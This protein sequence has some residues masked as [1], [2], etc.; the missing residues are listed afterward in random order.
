MGS[1]DVFFPDFLENMRTY[2][3][4]EHSKRFFIVTDKQ[5]FCDNLLATE[6]DVEC[7]VK[8]DVG[9]PYESLYR[10]NY[11]KTSFTPSPAI[12]HIFFLN[13]N[14]RCVDTVNDDILGS[15]VAVLHNMFID[16][17]YDQMSFEKNPISTAYV[18]PEGHFKYFGARF[19]GA[20]TEN[21]LKMC[22]MLDRNTQIDESNHFIAAWHDESH[23]NHYINVVLDQQGVKILGPE[24]HIPEE[25]IGTDGL[26]VAK[27]AAKV[28]YLDK[29]L[30]PDFEA[31]KSRIWQKTI[32]GEVN[33]H[34]SP[35]DL[36]AFRAGV[37][38]ALNPQLKAFS[39]EELRIH[40]LAH[41]ETPYFYETAVFAALFDT[42][43]YMKLYGLGS[44]LM[45]KYHYIR[46]GA[47]SE[48]HTFPVR[49]SNVDDEV[50]LS[51]WWQKGDRLE[52]DLTH[53]RKLGV[54]I[55]AGTPKPT[56]SPTQPP[57]AAPVSGI[58]RQ[59]TYTNILICTSKHNRIRT[60][61]LWR[62][63]T[64]VNLRSP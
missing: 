50:F 35:L 3:L 53:R 14:S 6:A 33:F 1:Y 26:D 9:W 45:A 17:A 41:P 22:D 20:T 27:G 5:D 32:G 19:L 63:I 39:D 30:L 51:Y 16:S 40:Y 58:L 11:F 29:K 36:P 12:S 10:W 55:Y 24:Y 7:S 54:S 37:Y 61:M 56:P 13:A 42:A 8:E 38:R 15:H 46:I 43:K 60:S 25:L 21:F 48:D 44:E 62:K 64:C 28:I 49:G 47:W 31:A 23:Y 2:F 4:P 18:P 57:T 52:R 59:R 34:S